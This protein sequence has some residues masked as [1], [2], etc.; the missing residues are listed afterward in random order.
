MFRSVRQPDCADVPTYSDRHLLASFPTYPIVVSTIAKVAKTFGNS[1]RIRVGYCSTVID[2]GSHGVGSR[3]ARNRNYPWLKALGNSDVPEEI[4]LGSRRYR[5]VERFKHDFFAATA[6]Y[7]CLGGPTSS[8]GRQGCRDKVVLK[9]GRVADLMGLPMRFVGERLA[10][11]EAGFYS[12]LQGLEGVPG[13]LGMWGGYGVVHEYVEGHPLRRNEWVNDEFFPRL[14][15]LLD[16]IHARDMAYV[17]LEKRE[18]IL[19]GDDGNPYLIDFQIS[20]GLSTPRLRRSRVLRFLL[21]KLQESDRYHLLKHHRRHRPDQ[22]S[23][24]QIEA[25]YRRPKHVD[26]HRVFFRPWTLLRRRTLKRMYGGAW[27]PREGGR[28]E[29]VPRNGK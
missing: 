2:Q 1:A 11:R 5:L 22:L 10:R 14:A 16:A 18:N 15:R 4:R 23:P 29:A 24:E 26:L 7:E 6:L 19:V 3:M 9:L 8:G 13:F 12:V 28:V 27:A 17:D 21:R 20:F 25:S